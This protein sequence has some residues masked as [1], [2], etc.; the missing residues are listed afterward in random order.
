MSVHSGTLLPCIDTVFL[1]Y[2]NIISSNFQKTLIIGF[3]IN[4]WRP[5]RDNVCSSK[6]NVSNVQTITGTLCIFPFFMCIAARFIYFTKSAN[7]NYC[8]NPFS[9]CTFCYVL[10]SL[11]TCFEQQ[12]CSR[13]RMLYYVLGSIFTRLVTQN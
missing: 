6:W 9:S 3:M 11:K 10:G 1:K 8:I 5:F 7:A 13:L 2:I 4:Y 12:I